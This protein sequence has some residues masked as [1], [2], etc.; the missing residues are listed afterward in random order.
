MKRF[1]FNL[2]IILLCGSLLSAALLVPLKES[3]T[4]DPQILETIDG[5]WLHAEIYV[6]GRHVNNYMLDDPVLVAGGKVYVPLDVSA[7]VVHEKTDKVGRAEGAAII[8]DAEQPQTQVA[9]SSDEDSMP[10]VPFLKKARPVLEY[11]G[12]FDHAFVGRQLTTGY[13]SYKGVPL[14]ASD[15]LAF[16]ANGTC[17]GSEDFL[18]NTLGIDVCYRPSVGLYLSTDPEVSAERW[19]NSDTNLSFSEGMRMYIQTINPYLTDEQAKEYEFLMRHVCAQCAYITPK[20]LFGVIYTESR[21]YAD[22]GTGAVGLMQILL[23]YA[24][25][26]GYTREALWDPHVNMEYG[27][28]ML[29][30]YIGV[31]NGDVSWAMAA[32]N[33]GIG[34]VRGNPNYD[35]YYS[36]LILKRIAIFEE[37]L[38]ASGR[39]TDFTEQLVLID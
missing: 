26:A 10:E 38:V 34:A 33:Q 21:F 3:E 37:W 22:A 19:A 24:E 39:S 23:S 25:M 18:R 20:L 28:P 17:Y 2:I 7:L 11:H 16:D 31:F 9:V 35:R 36:N 27:A 13:K 8:V 4:E 12:A 32:Y 15:D 6:D 14:V 30:Y 29:D 1:V 5:E